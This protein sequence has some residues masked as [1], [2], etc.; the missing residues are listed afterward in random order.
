MYVHHVHIFCP[1]R[2][3]KG[4]RPLELELQR[5]VS[6]HSGAE[7]QTWILYNSN[8]CSEPQSSLQIPVLWK[9]RVELKPFQWTFVPYPRLS[10][11]DIGWLLTMLGCT[12]RMLW[13]GWI[14]VFSFAQSDQPSIMQVSLAFTRFF[15]TELFFFC[16]KRSFIIISKE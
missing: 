16:L 14:S 9:I 5:L 8:M 1:Q 3:K 10:V 12:E 15:K 13:F 2:T 11:L 6:H 4:I 7:N